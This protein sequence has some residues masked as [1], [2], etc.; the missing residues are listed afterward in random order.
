[1]HAK[2]N[3]IHLLVVLAG[4]T[5]DGDYTWLQIYVLRRSYNADVVT[6]IKIVDNWGGNGRPSFNFRSK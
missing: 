3:R 2:E 1:M 4:N 6:P 5:S